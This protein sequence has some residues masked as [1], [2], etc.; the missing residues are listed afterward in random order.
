MERFLKLFTFLP[1]DQVEELS[2]LEGSAINQAKQVLAFEVTKFV[3]GEDEAKQA[4]A[5]AQ[6]AF[7]GGAQA[8][9]V[10][11]STMDK[12]RLAEGVP[13]FLLFNE[14]GLT[15]SSS[16]ARRLIKQGGAYVGEQRVEAFDQPITLD[17]AGDDGAIWLRAGKK[18]HHRVVPE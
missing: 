16:E 1:M 2:R 17:M 6:A 13:A 10:P 9:G 5:A 14:V 3:H 15:K 11:S 8:D 4:Q 7:S 12:A 18:K